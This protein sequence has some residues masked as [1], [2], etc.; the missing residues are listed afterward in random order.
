MKLPHF[1]LRKLAD[2]VVPRLPGDIVRAVTFPSNQILH[3]ASFHLAVQDILQFVQIFFIVD[4][5]RW[6]LHTTGSRTLMIRLK[7]FR[8][9]SNLWHSIFNT[10]SP[11]SEST[12]T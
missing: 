10:C 5:W 9:T 1:V 11:T 8:M 12:A 3:H 6:G 7:L 4:W 2:H